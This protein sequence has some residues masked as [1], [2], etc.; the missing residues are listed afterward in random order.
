MEEQGLAFGSGSRAMQEEK[1]RADHQLRE[2]QDAAYLAALQIDKVCIYAD[3]VYDVAIN[4]YQIDDG[5]TCSSRK[6]V[7]SKI[8]QS[9]KNQYEQLQSKTPQRNRLVK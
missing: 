1:R 2:E 3:M 5:S 6:R 8:T 9:R 7:D 4:G